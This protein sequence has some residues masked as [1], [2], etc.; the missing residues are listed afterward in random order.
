MKYENIKTPRELSE[1]MQ[2]N[3]KY[4]FVSK[5]GE[6]YDEPGN[7]EW[8]NDWYHNCIV[9][10]GESLLKTKYG[11][12]W[13]QVELARKWFE[14]N[15]FNYKTIYIWFEVN[16]PSNLPTH[17]FLIYE[18]NDKYYWFENA[19]EINKGIHEFNSNDEVIEHVKREQLK[20]AIDTKRATEDDYSCIT[21]YEYLK[22]KLN[23]SVDE[24]F[25]HVTTANKYINSK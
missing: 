22:P 2:K 13:D 9:Q 17:T 24:Y 25:E 10:D 11:T 19:F 6:I 12:C 8:N 1:Y 14:E 20:Y 21:A 5:S 23:L 16:R 15:N 3:I 18:E 7:E 4:G